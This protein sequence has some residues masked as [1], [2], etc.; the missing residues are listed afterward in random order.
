MIVT[1]LNNFPAENTDVIFNYQELNLTNDGDTAQD[2]LPLPFPNLTELKDTGQ[3]ILLL[4]IGSGDDFVS[5]D[6]V[7]IHSKHCQDDVDEDTNSEDGSDEDDQDHD[8]V[9]PDVLD[10][11]E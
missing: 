2:D 5:L 11:G 4:I 10:D 7:S 8:V 9:S 6:V 3:W 1:K